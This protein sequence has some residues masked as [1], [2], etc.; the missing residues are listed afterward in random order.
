MQ[1]KRT[2]EDMMAQVKEL[3]EDNN[4]DHERSYEEGIKDTL[5][6]ILEIRDELNIK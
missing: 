2:V 3:I 5:E 4:V 1:N 6:W